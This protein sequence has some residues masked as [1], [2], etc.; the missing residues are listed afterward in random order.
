MPEISIERAIKDS[1]LLGAALGSLDTWAVWTA[2]LKAA[3]ALPLSADERALF[4]A[5]AGSRNPP[6]QRVREL[7]AWLA[8]VA[9]SRGSRR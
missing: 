7:C 1:R 6:S 8:G 2:V 3:F 5:V 9:A 4:T